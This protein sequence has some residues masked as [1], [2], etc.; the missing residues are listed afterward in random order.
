MEET[1]SNRRKEEEEI[2]RLGEQREKNGA[3]R[4]TK[5][6]NIQLVSWKRE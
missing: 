1:I 4:E 3:R 5:G 6:R 2:R